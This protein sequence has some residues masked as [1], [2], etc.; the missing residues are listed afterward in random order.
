LG[1]FLA[2]KRRK[3]PA[4][5]QTVRDWL[6]KALEEFSK[7]W[8]KAKKQARSIQDDLAA[9][10]QGFSKK[11][12]FLIFPHRTIIRCISTRTARAER[13]RATGADVESSVTDVMRQSSCV[14]CSS[15]NP[16]SER[17]S[18]NVEKDFSFSAPEI[19]SHREV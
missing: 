7:Q 19:A 8:P 2:S 3:E 17:W 9:Q 13:E 6:E 4:A 12:R 1:A 11:L 15:R 5:V 16:P 14:E 18:S 10:A